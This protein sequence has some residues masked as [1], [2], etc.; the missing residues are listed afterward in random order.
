MLGAESLLGKY[1]TCL[2]AHLIDILTVA[3]QVGSKSNRSYAAVC[4]ILSEDVPGM[5][6]SSTGLV[7]QLAVPI[8]PIYQ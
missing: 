6:I 8:A 1:A 5:W 3:S 2:I 4:A 7:A